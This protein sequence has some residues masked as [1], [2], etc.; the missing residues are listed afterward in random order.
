MLASPATAVKMIAELCDPSLDP[1]LPKWPSPYQP[2]SCGGLVEDPPHA[3]SSFSLARTNAP[4]CWWLF[5]G[6]VN[7]GCNATLS[8]VS[9]SALSHTFSLSVHWSNSS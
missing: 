3:V 4:M 1:P 2:V 5:S 8:V 7:D 6:G 9:T